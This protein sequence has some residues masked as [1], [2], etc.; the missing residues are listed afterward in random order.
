MSATLPWMVSLVA[1][2]SR[3]SVLSMCVTFLLPQKCRGRRGAHRSRPPLAERYLGVLMTVSRCGSGV[4]QFRGVLP[5]IAIPSSVT[6][7]SKK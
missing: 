7:L 6:L 3:Q 2:T 4:A 5:D 1:P